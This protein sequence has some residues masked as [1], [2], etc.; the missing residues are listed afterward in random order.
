MQARRHIFR[1]GLELR[2][3][4]GSRF[5]LPA[6]SRRSCLPQPDQN[7]RFR[8]T[9]RALLTTEFSPSLLSERSMGEILDDSLESAERK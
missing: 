7:L 2:F 8:R 3:L 9:L 1:S 4:N 5:F 6:G